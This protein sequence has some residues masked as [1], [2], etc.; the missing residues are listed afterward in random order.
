MGISVWRLRFSVRFPGGETS[1]LG[2]LRFLWGFRMSTSICRLRF[3]EGRDSVLGRLAG[4]LR[5]S[6]LRGGD[7]LADVWLESVSSEVLFVGHSSVLEL[8]E[9][10]AGVVGIGVCFRFLAIFG[11]G[12]PAHIRF[13]VKAASRWRF[14]CLSRGFFSSSSG[15]SR[16]CVRFRP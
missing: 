15:S 9:S 13:R 6:S 16:F 4:L 7:G 12:V 2:C 5:S 14:H 10:A 8:A 1:D 3:P 11:M